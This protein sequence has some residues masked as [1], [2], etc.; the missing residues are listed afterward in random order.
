MTK[1][2]EAAIELLARRRA[3]QSVSE[4]IH[5]TKPDYIWS[6]FSRKICAACDKFLEDMNRWSGNLMNKECIKRINL[7]NKGPNKLAF[8][9]FSTTTDRI[10]LMEFVKSKQRD[11]NKSFIPITNGQVFSLE[12][13]DTSRPNNI[14]FRTVMTERNRE[15]FNAIRAEKKKN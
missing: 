5:Y 14:E 3:R 7:I 1:Q 12:P 9:H 13:N 10:K 4:Y 6:E 8:I 11:A 15:I 2:Q